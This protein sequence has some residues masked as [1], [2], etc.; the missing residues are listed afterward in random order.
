MRKLLSAFFSR[1][2]KDVIFWVVL[3]VYSVL[4]LVSCLLNYQSSVQYP[5]DPVY[6]EDVLFNMIPALPFLCAAV[7][8]LFLGQE[9]D[10]NTIR[11]KLTVGHTRT[12]IF[13][14]AYAAC[15]AAS[16]ALLGST[17][18]LSGVTGFLCFKAF[19][20]DWTQLV[21]LAACC[22]LVTMVFSAICVAFCMNIQKRA[23]S[24]LVTLVVML[25]LL[26]AASYLEG[27][28]LEPEMTY[29]GITISTVDG[30]QFGDLVKNPAY[31]SGNARKV[32][33]FIFDM[34]PTGQAVQLNNMELERCGRWLWLSAIML[35]IITL[36]GFLP[37]RKHDIR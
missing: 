24:I 33:E 2:R 5:S 4:S 29:E 35:P 16:L 21:Y 14:S 10:E 20:L 34:L 8:A 18:I 3:V 36:A 12:A 30:V 6:V 26:F 25:V 19:L 32:M 22:V 23:I 7:I 15:T 1:L 13:F 11:N 31:V 17:L 27:A 37:F 9:F 28:L